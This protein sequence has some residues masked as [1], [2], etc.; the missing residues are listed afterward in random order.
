MRDI[1]ARWFSEDSLPGDC[2]ADGIQNIID[3]VLL[4]NNCILAEESDCGCGD[5][6]EDG[7]V[8]ILDIVQ[9]VN[10]ILAP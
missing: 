3:I 8:N 2:N 4:I 9:L 1:G 10:L 6:N 5:M 7:E